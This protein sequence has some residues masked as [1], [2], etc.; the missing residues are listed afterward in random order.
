MKIAY[1]YDVVHPYVIGGAQKRIW[2]LSTRLA[3]RGHQVTIFGMKYWAGDDIVVRQ[4]VRLWGVCPP[5]PLFVNGRRSVREAIYYAWKVTPPLMKER[6]D[7]VDAVNFP[8]FPCL[9]AAFHSLTRRSKLAITWHE[10]WGQYW[11][12]Y[13]GAKG[14]FGKA[15][16]RTV[17]CLPQKAIAV[18]QA[19]KRDLDTLADKDAAVVPNGADIEA[20]DNAPLSN[21]PADIIY[22][23]R[24]TREK[25][26]ILLIK[27]VNLI[28][29]QHRSI[30]C[31][32]IGD[33]PEKEVLQRQVSDLGVSANIHFKGH[34]ERDTEVFSYMK[35]ARVLV[36]PSLREGFGI[37][38]VEANACGIPVITVSHHRNAARDLVRNGYNGFVCEMSEEDMAKKI[39]LALDPAQDWGTRCR[40]SA[41]AYDWNTV[42]DSLEEVYKAM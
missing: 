13:L 22:A 23:G 39:R 14:L 32:V 4:S 27:A 30:R 29:E 18:S 38:V 20:I 33:G 9:S 36:L 1:V 16:E 31:L 11:Y 3:G 28:R 41:S 26:V 17:A 25:N 34:L 6:Y 15:A 8:F 42:V 21:E 35:S 10:V 12:E 37:V 7:I 19:T 40:E 24:L 2:E 5:Q